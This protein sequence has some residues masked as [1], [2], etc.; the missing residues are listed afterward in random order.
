MAGKK[1]L[2]GK[3]PFGGNV[4]KN[5]ASCSKFLSFKYTRKLYNIDLQETTS[6]GWLWVVK[7]GPCLFYF[8]N[9]TTLND[10][11]SVILPPLSIPVLLDNLG[12]CTMKFKEL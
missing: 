3:G 5:P 6:H 11:A 9:Y 1:L 7:R 2:D 12:T 10:S 4:F 8:L